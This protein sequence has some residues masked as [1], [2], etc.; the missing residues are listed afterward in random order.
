VAVALAAVAK[1]ED[2][3][4]YQKQSPYTLVTVTE[5]DSGLRTLSF[6]KNQVRQSVAKVGDPDHL[7]LPYARVMPAALAFVE[8]PRRVLIIGL[9]GASIP[10][11]LHKHF[12]KTVIDTVDIDP[13]VVEVARKFFDFRED[14]TMRAHVGDGRKFVESVRDPYDIIMLDAYGSDNIPYHLATREFLLAVRR[15]L[16]PDGVVV[17][18]VWD[19]YSNSLYDSMVKTYVAAF[20][21]LY[22]FDV[23]DAGNRIL[24]GLPR[25][26][27][28]GRQEVRSR[29]A[30]IVQAHGFRFDLADLL[31]QGYHRADA[32]SWAGRI[33]V[34]ADKP[35]GQ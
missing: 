13:D 3:V 29:A 6:D 15:A 19:R 1:A 8:R 34:D 17:G 26:R 16:A 10:N 31:W 33:L 20:E 4:L 7:E 9:G 23:P 27:P 24:V 14:A 32:E 5:N 2:K 22:Q 18:N 12:P 11:F 28:L 25:G 30:A 21:V 35:Q